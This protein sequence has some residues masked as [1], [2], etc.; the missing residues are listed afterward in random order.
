M[1]RDLL[2][3]LAALTQWVDRRI[4][5]PEAVPVEYFHGA[6]GEEIA[7]VSICS[8]DGRLLDAGD[9]LLVPGPGATQQTRARLQGLRDR[10]AS[11]Q[12]GRHDQ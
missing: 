2:P 11:I 7:D 1:G 6:T 5:G 9:I 3:I 12:N 10:C 8:K 4:L